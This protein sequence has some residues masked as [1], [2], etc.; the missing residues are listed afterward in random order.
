MTKRVTILMGGWSSEREVSLVSGEAVTEA[1]KESG[2]E[3]QTVDVKRDLKAL[4]DALTPKPDVVFNALH[5]RYGE[6]GCIQGVLEVLGVPYTHSGVAASALAMDKPLAKILFDHAGI[7][8]APHVVATRDELIKGRVMDPPYVVKPLNEG[9]SVGV[10]IVLTDKDEKAFRAGEWPFGDTVMVERYVA[11][12]EITVS[13]M[14]D[15]ALG[16]TEIKPKKGFYDYRAKYTEGVAD[17][18]VPAQL[19]VKIYQDAME[20]AVRAHQILGCR[21]VSRADLRYDDTAGEPGKLCVLE[22]NTQPGLTP[23]SLV[24]EAAASVDI[25]FAELVT[26]MVENAACDA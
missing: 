15:R 5:G 18:I 11:G 23:L 2:Y 16:V 24:P 8:C 26:W 6:D 21:G 7:P 17:H 4:N 1:L 13:V 20:Y 10:H 19:P 14:G 3:T 22:V 25:G 12:R 9:S